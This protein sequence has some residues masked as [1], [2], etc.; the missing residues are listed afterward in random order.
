MHFK[1]ESNLSLVHIIGAGLAGLSAAVELTQAGIPVTLSDQAAR[2]GGRC[3]SYHDPQLGMMID[4]GNHLVFSGNRAVNVYLATIGASER[5]TGPD[6]AEFA[7]HDLRDGTRW[8]MRASDGRIPWWVFQTS[9]RTPGTSVADHLPLARLMTAN[10]EATVGDIV[11]TSGTFWKRLAEPVLLAV[12]NTE[13]AKGS[14]K[15]AGQ[16]VRESLAKGGLASRPMIAT[17]TLD[18]AFVDPA[19]AWLGVR[20]VVPQFGQRLRSIGSDGDRATTLDFG[21]G[22]ESIEGAAVILAVPAWV[23]AELVPG[24]T[25]PD[26]HS[27]ILNAHFGYPAPAGS[28]PMTGVI[29]SLSQWVF[30]FA[31]RISVT[32]SAADAVI[33]DDREDLAR[34]IWEEVCQTLSITAPLPAWQIVKEKRATFAATPAQDAK[35]PFAATRWRNLFLAGDWTQTGLPA[36]IEGALRSGVTAAKLVQ[37]V[38]KR[39]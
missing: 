32:V 39:D 5:L 12:L 2:A 1:R 4:N 8:T 20:G 37:K 31:D 34:R 27:A 16:V 38:R 30:A 7:F 23:A 18:A 22:A 24:L 36:T 9:R 33:D 13:A 6:H 19:L 35:R 14:A 17:P 25:V 21:G 29:G 26:Q 15:L 10:A 3:R 11:P 28:A